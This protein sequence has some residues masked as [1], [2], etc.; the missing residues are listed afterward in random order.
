MPNGEKPKCTFITVW[1]VGGLPSDCYGH[2]ANI[3][4]WLSSKKGHFWHILA[5]ATVCH[6]NQTVL[7]YKLDR[8]QIHLQNSDRENIKSNM[9]VLRWNLV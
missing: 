7:E 6:G 1:D 3:I 8:N 5:L 9:N 4:G 2:N